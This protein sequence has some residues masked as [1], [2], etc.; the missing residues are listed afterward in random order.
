MIQTFG[1]SY[2]EVMW[3]ISWFKLLRMASDLPRQ[4]KISES[5]QAEVKELNEQT[6]DDFK[7]EIMKIN[8]RLKK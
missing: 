6:A 4:E 7:N 1:L 5:K 2:K 3:E 8:Q